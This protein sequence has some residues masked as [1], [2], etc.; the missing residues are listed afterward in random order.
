MRKYSIIILSLTV[1]VLIIGI[2]QIMVN[3]LANSYWILMFAV[4]GLL[5]YQ[6]INKHTPAPPA[7]EEAEKSETSAPSK[8][9]ARTRKK[10]KKLQ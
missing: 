9:I 3:G 6:Y 10:F 4:F 8:N 2:H 7:E 1:G 5:G